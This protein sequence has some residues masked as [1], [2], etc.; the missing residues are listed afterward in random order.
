MKLLVTGGL[1]F[2]GSNFIRHMLSAHPDCQITNLDKQT[3]AGNPENLKEFKKNSHYTW[4]KA[5][6]LDRKKVDACMSR[7]E[8]VVHFAAETHV[9]RSIL[10]SGDFIRTN[11]LGT[12]VLLESA[13]ASGVK[14]FVHVSTD[15]VYGSKETGDSRE[16]DVLLPNSPYASSKAAS[17]LL[18]RSY[19]VTYGFPVIVT[20]SSNN[21]GPYQYPEKAIPLLITNALEDKSFP[22]YGDGLQVRDWLYVLDHA[23]ALDT[24]L[25]RGVPGEIYNIG[26]TRSCANVDL[27]KNIL[28]LMNKSESLIQRIPDRPG[29]DRRYALNCDRLRALG[30]KPRASFEDAL[31][32]TIGWYKQNKPWWSKIKSGREYRTYYKKQYVREGRLAVRH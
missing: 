2:I 15:E 23:K 32:Q 12:Q 18:A 28:N 13:K 1:G 29:H 14:R 22:L 3:Y 20:R 31:R 4:V 6:I 25:E 17:D 30:W 8:A 24:V 16:E 10:D 19:F 9:D 21:F 11:V 27:V 26:G 5:D 7:V